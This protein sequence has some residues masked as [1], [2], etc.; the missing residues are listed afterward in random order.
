MPER[1]LSLQH[2]CMWTDHG[3]QRVTTEIAAERGR[4]RTISAESGL[5]KC[6][7]CGQ[8]VT[9]V[10]GHIYRPF[11]KHSRGEYDKNCPERTFVSPNQERNNL[12]QTIKNIHP[13]RLVVGTGYSFYVE[14]G[15]NPIDPSILD[16]IK[17][18]TFS[19]VSDDR[20]R[21][22]YLFGRVNSDAITYFKVKQ[23][24]STYF[25]ID[26]ESD[27][28]INLSIWQ[29]RIPG[30]G[31]HALFQANGGRYVHQFSEVTLGKKYYLVTEKSYFS[32]QNAVMVDE[33]KCYGRTRLYTVTAVQFNQKAAEFFLDL[34]YYLTDSPVE[35]TVLWP[36][37]VQNS[38][39]IM[40]ST[41]YL[42]LLV[43]GDGECEMYPERKNNVYRIG[44]VSLTKVV[45]SNLQQILYVSKNSHLLTYSYL[46]KDSRTYT[47]YSYEE[48][49]V[50]D[51]K[52]NQIIPGSISE[53]LP[54]ELVFKLKYDGIL[55][56]IV[57]GFLE[58]T[59]EIKADIDQRI[60]PLKRNREYRIYIGI[61][62]GWYLSIL[63]EPTFSKRSI[64]DK[65]LREKTINH[66][67]GNIMQNMNDFPLSKCWI[68]KCIK[69]GSMPKDA[70]D[71][72][73]ELKGD[74]HARRIN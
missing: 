25:D 5:L 41:H 50:Y 19:I 48:I 22:T 32:R 37:I 60:Y 30:P 9:F 45:L 55:E 56:I 11:F 26:I 39:T 36:P 47:D 28:N 34:H 66:S 20:S 15:L 1:N 13:L 3:W 14:I 10:C 29:Q 38:E 69:K 59:L 58:D 64:N 62:C 35:Y 43:K 21:N 57:N 46:K 23:P 17:G 18:E 52:K 12:L 73:C 67:F 8:N 33:L 49:K 27:C 65:K 53:K 40:F 6:E 42:Y 71:L 2:V 63:S 74:N 72:L 70:Y 54:K 16:R 24:L 31:E 51:E 61:D 68:R 4:G 7:L 44:D